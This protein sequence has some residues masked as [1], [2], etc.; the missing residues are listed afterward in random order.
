MSP[1]V[2]KKPA[3][4]VPSLFKSPTTKTAKDDDSKFVIIDTEY[5]FDRSK[6]S[7]H[8][9]EVLKKRRDDIPS[10]YQ[11]L[12]QDTQSQSN[13]LNDELKNC[14]LKDVLKEGN[15]IEAN[16][17]EAVVVLNKTEIVRDENCVGDKSNSKKN[18]L[19]QSVKENN[20]LQ[21]SKH[22]NNSGDA[23]ARSKKGEPTKLYY[24]SLFLLLF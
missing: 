23:K 14:D 15:Q 6:L 9:K 5:K 8:Q 20:N 7:E 18:D 19:E 10:L 21:E 1:K 22:E 3:N 4:V 2:Q 17:S 24:L 13:S 11:D 16:K 12:S